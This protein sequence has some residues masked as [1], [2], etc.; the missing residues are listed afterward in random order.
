MKS[1]CGERKFWI[2]VAKGSRHGTSSRTFSACPWDD[3]IISG[4]EY[5][6]T[7]YQVDGP[8]QKFREGHGSYATP[9][10]RA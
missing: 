8:E 6:F 4:K 10:V 5:P 2:C 9:D 3:W 1:A 7:A